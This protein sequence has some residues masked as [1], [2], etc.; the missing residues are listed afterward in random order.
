MQKRRSQAHRTAALMTELSINGRKWEREAQIGCRCK[1]QTARAGKRAKQ[2]SGSSETIAPAEMPVKARSTKAAAGGR[3]PVLS[4]CHYILCFVMVL[5]KLVLFMSVWTRSLFT[6]LLSALRVGGPHSLDTFQLFVKSLNRTPEHVALIFNEEQMFVNDIASAVVCCVVVGIGS[7]SLYDHRG[8][9]K[10][11]RTQLEQAVRGALRLAE[12]QLGRALGV[13]FVD[14]AKAQSLA[15]GNGHSNGTRHVD[16]LANGVNGCAGHNGCAAL[17][18]GHAAPHDDAQSTVFTFSFADSRP[19]FAKTVRDMIAHESPGD[20]DGLQK[21][22]WNTEMLDRA[23]QHEFQVKSEPQLAVVF[24]PCLTTAG[25]PPWHVRL[26]EFV[27][28]PTHRRFAPRT[29]LDAFRRFAKCEQ[30]FGK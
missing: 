13:R 1:R 28:V 11:R 21:R 20:A 4:L 14:C 9:L 23:I 5:C 15:N 24:G 2:R 10:A 12:K 17:L 27:H 8:M 19:R 18:N 6:I 30:R 25:Y 16:Q 7:I 26:T 29:L 3:T 22:P